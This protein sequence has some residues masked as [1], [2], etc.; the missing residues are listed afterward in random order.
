MMKYAPQNLKT[1][2]FTRETGA[3]ASGNSVQEVSQ[4][5]RRIVGTIVEG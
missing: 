1:A 3:T 5:G 4:D 2:V